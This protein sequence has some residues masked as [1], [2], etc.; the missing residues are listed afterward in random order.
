MDGV[1]VHLEGVSGLATGVPACMDRVESLL[2]GAF[3]PDRF[4]GL[5]VLPRIATRAGLIRFV[6]GEESVDRIV[7]VEQAPELC[8]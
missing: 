4:A 1:L 2:C 5:P 7:A 6:E 8:T 3:A